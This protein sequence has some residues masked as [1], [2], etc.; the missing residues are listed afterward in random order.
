MT[1]LFLVII[2][3]YMI[4]ADIVGCNWIELEIS[5]GQWQ[6]R[7]LQSAVQPVS[8]YSIISKTILIQM[9]F[10]K[11]SYNEMRRCQIEVDVA[12]TQVKSHSPEGQWADVAPLR[13]LSF[14][15]ECAGRKGADCLVVGQSPTR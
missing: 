8:R 10:L 3:R 6:I 11:L 14:D 2:I 9:I 4:D 13:I 5:P 1:L 15:I 7:D 12:W